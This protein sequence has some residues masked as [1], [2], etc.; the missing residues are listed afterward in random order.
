MLAHDLVSHSHFRNRID[1]ANEEGPCHSGYSRRRRLDILLSGTI[2]V[3][4]ARPSG[5]NGYWL[6]SCARAHD[7]NRWA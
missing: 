7:I 6:S 5:R 4:R 2:D 3:D 1:N